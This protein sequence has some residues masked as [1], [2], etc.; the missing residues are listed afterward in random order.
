METRILL[1]T[2]RQRL[3]SRLPD[4][5]IGFILLLV[6]P[7]ILVRVSMGT[8]SV[9]VTWLGVG[10]WEG[11]SHFKAGGGSKVRFWFPVTG[12]HLLHFL[13]PLRGTSPT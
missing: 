8:R 10:G 6:V 3:L 1:L 2:K 9:I 7:F 4:S 11:G 13:H 5:Q 12:F